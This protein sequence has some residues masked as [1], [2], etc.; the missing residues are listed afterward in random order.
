MHREMALEGLFPGEAQRNSP[1]QSNSVVYP[2]LSEMLTY[3][4]EQQPAI[5]DSSGVGDIKLLFPS[6]TYVAMVKFLLKCFETEAAQTNLAE[7]SGYIQSAESLCV[8]LEHAMTY[9]GSVELH[10][11]ASKALI[12]VGS[13][14]PQ[15][16]VMEFLQKKYLEICFLIAFHGY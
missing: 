13:H 16:D 11:S 5:L 10:A 7:D 4:L 2:K 3:I 12:T 15:V 8:L 1:S 9:E 14:Y 6:K